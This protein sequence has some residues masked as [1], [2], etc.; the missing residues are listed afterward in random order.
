MLQC[1]RDD[2][3]DA[4]D[5]VNLGAPALRDVLSERASTATTAKVTAP[6]TETIDVDAA[7]EWTF[8]LG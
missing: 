6:V 8:K 7:P 1:M 5:L 2:E 3:L 4:G